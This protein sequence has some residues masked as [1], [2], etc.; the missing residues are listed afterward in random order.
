[1]A[2]RERE[3][4][5]AIPCLAAIARQM[6][7]QPTISR[8]LGT[9]EDILQELLSEAWAMGFKDRLPPGVSRRKHLCLKA[10]RQVRWRAKRRSHRT[11]G[12]EFHAEPVER[13]SPPDRQV[14]ARLDAETIVAGLS[15]RDRQILLR[16]G[17]LKELAEEWGEPVQALKTRNFLLVRKLRKKWGAA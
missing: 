2:E 12:T 5:A 16:E 9:R 14:E 8:W 6:S 1:M 13:L 7:A 17:T 15:P 3:L 11:L 4:L 10:A